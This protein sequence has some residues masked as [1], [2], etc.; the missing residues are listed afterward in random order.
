MVDIADFS[1]EDVQKLFEDK[2][3]VVIGDSGQWTTQN[4]TFIVSIHFSF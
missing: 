2:Q 1:S 3:V 4:L